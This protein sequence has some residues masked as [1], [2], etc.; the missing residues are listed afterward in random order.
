MFTIQ[1]GHGG[2]ALSLWPIGP[3]PSTTMRLGATAACVLVLG[4]MPSYA[5]FFQQFFQQGPSHG[6]FHTGEQ[7][8]HSVGDASWYQERVKNGTS[9]ALTQPNAMNTYAATPLHAYLSQTNA[10][11]LMSSRS[12][13]HSAMDTCV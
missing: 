6:F 3:F 13:V 1:H 4:A 8:A 11:A 9:C 5:Q 10:H 2:V 12:G 7:E